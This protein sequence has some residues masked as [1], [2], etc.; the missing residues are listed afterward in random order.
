MQYFIFAQKALRQKVDLLHGYVK[1][2]DAELEKL[3]QILRKERKKFKQMQ[4]YDDHLNEQA[5][6][7]EILINKTRPDLIDRMKR[8]DV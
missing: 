5:M 1:T 3:K 2:Q 6:Q 8:P 7:F 4:S